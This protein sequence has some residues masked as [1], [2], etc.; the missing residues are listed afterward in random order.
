M[1]LL[2]SL[3]SRA[4]AFRSESLGE[5]LLPEMALSGFD[6]LV[7]LPLIFYFHLHPSIAWVS[8]F[9]GG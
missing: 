8:I 4:I 6:F 2:D 3:D 7:S 1:T 5:D 9:Y